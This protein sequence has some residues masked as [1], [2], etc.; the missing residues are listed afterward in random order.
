MSTTTTGTHEQIFDERDDVLYASL[1]GDPHHAF[2]YV[3]GYAEERGRSAGR[4]SNINV[5]LPAGTDDD[6]YLAALEPVLDAIAGFPVRSW[7]SR[8]DSTRTRSI[9]GAIWT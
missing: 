8:S 5:P 7:W 1:H 3:V 6:S 2:P 4:G 9:R